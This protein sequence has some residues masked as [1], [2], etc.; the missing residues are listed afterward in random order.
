M[1][2]ILIPQ[3][4]KEFYFIVSIIIYLLKNHSAMFPLN[5]I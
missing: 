2:Q 5:S 3:I 1:F 4:L